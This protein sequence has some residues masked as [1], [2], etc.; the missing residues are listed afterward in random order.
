MNG[1]GEYRPY[2]RPSIVLWIIVF[3]IGALVGGGVGS[4]ITMK[5]FPQAK[6]S[7]STQTPTK[8]QIIETTKIINLEE[9]QIIKVAEEAGPAVVTISTKKIVSGFFFTYETPALGSGFIIS[10]DGDIVTNYHV[11]EDAKDITVTLSDGRE[12][13]GFIVG[14]DPSSDV[15]L[16]KIKAKDLPHLVFADSS[17]LKV[18]QMVVAIGNPYGLDHTVTSGVVSALE[19]T[20]S[21]E[22]GRTL[23]GVIQTDAAINP[24]N[25]GG[26]LL[27]M[28]GEVIGMNTAIKSGAQGIGFAVSSNTVVKVVSDLNKYGKV[29]WPFLGIGGVSINEDIA[30]R[31][32][33]PVDKGVLV[34]KVYPNTAAD[35][36]GLK[37]F[38]II[39]KFDGK[40]VTTVQ[41]LTKYIREHEVGDTVKI[42][43]IRG[44]KH[45]ILNATLKER[46]RSIGKIDQSYLI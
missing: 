19:R 23:V 2:R 25:S 13:T 8:T 37:E 20:L 1:F 18:G 27:N 17:K 35:K 16:L 43:I 34:L 31:E 24:G 33:L 36:A 30:K 22:D 45:M 41:E 4:F 12:F 6:E 42:E 26:P 5:Y 40:E 44:K 32:K 39:T 11:I 9:S 7:S 38:D 15:A 29:V 21:F 28:A 10:S 46:P 3:L 14:T